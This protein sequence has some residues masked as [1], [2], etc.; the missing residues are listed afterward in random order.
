MVT[1]WLLIKEF[2]ISAKDGQSRKPQR[3]DRKL[4]YFVILL[5]TLSSEAKFDAN[6]IRIKGSILVHSGS[7][8]SIPE[9]DFSHIVAVIINLITSADNV[10]QLLAF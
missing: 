6:L 8:Y 3:F 5:L 9:V 4:L 7:L 1:A 10:F 2:W